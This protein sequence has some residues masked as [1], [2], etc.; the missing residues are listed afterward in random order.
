MDI[1]LLILKGDNESQLAYYKALETSHTQNKT[2]PFNEVV[3]NEV[4]HSLEKYL[5]IIEG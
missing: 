3:A 1:P 5:S 2:E 4:V